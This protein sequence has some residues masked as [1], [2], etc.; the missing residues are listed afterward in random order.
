MKPKTKKPTKTSLIKK[1]DVLY[2]LII[3]VRG[4]CE[5]CGRSDIQL[6]AHHIVGRTNFM[7]RYDFRN[8]CCLCVNCHEFAKDSVKNNPIKFLRWLEQNRPDDLKYVESKAN[9]IAHYSVEDL[10]MICKSLKEVYSG[11]QHI[12]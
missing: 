9:I 3:R 11:L 2:S 12:N 5:V 4:Y 1:C 8:G 7:L 6:N 10:Q